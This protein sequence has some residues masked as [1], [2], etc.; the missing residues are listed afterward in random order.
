[1]SWHPAACTTPG[2]LSGQVSGDPRG[3]SKPSCGGRAAL[4]PYSSSAG[5]TGR[6]RGFSKSKGLSFLNLENPSRK[7]Q[8]AMTQ[9][10]TAKETLRCA[11]GR[12]SSVK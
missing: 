4:S 11:W 10:H 9:C 8:G 2:Q 12:I 6:P 3:Q 1:M 5:L 7:P